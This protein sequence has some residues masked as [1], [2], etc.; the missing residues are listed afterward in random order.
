[1]ANI[2]DIANELER[3]IRATEQYQALQKAFAD[4]KVEEEAYTLFKEF[5]LFQQTL[6]QKM[7]A[8][9]EM[10]E[11]DATRAQE[12]SQAIQTQNAIADL[13]EAEQAFSVLINDMNNIVMT[14]VR[15][16]YEEA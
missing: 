1:M 11:E 10:A 14:P 9:E 4:L 16:L 2:Y 15:E 3:E 13:M 5:Q 12:L 8:G 7:M 6:Q